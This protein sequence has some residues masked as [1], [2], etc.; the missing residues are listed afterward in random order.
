[1]PGSIG[2]MRI[3]FA[4]NYGLP[5]DALISILRLRK[6]RNRYPDRRN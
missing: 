4:D 3:E 1:M 6:V 2:G 5:S